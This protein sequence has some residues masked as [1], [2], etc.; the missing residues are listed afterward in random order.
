MN[1]SI[2]NMACQSRGNSS[3]TTQN[4][5]FNSIKRS[6]SIIN[7]GEQVTRDNSNLNLE[8]HDDDGIF[9]SQ[10]DFSLNLDKVD[11][12]FNNQIPSQ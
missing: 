4:N 9:D 10:M 7:D 5:T 8:S 11:A 2:S 12:S 1:Q 6:L 3:K